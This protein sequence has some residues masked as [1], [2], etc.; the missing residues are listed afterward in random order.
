[1]ESLLDAD[2]PA[3]A[4]KSPDGSF[5]TQDLADA[6]AAGDFPEWQLWIQT[7]PPADA[8]KFDFDPLDP[9]KARAGPGPGPR[10]CAA[11]VSHAAQPGSAATCGVGVHVVAGTS[12]GRAICTESAPALMVPSFWAAG[13]G[14]GEQHACEQLY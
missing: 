7:L 14:V 6:I 13:E 1:M 9:T 10:G 12:L 4:A 8:Q 5:A 2:I 11:H 3:L